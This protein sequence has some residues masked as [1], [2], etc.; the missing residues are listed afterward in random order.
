MKWNRILKQEPEEPKAHFVDPENKEDAELEK[1]KKFLGRFKKPQ[2]MSFNNF[3]IEFRKRT[4]SLEDLVDFVINLDTTEGTP[5]DLLWEQ[6]RQ[7]SFSLQSQVDTIKRG[8]GN[9]AN[10]IVRNMAETM[11]QYMAYESLGASLE[12][13][14]DGIKKFFSGTLNIRREAEPLIRELAKK[15]EAS[16]KVKQMREEEQQRKLQRQQKQQGQTTLN[17]FQQQPQGGQ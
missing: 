8:F 3:M 11:A 12:A 16:P 7:G 14:V 5:L 6:K 17:D 4:S 2:P 9:D 13:A 10:T 1:V 15:V